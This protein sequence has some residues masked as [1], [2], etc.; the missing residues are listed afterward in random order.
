M[1]HG[2]HLV[3]TLV[4]L[5]SAFKTQVVNATPPVASLGADDVICQVATTLAGN[6][7]TPGTGAWTIPAGP[8][9]QQLKLQE[10]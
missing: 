5:H 2:H 8:N 4:Q 9:T 7:A 6:T 3:H 10:A 1:Q